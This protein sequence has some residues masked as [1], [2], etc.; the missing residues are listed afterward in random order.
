MDST[1]RT[2]IKAVIWNVIG[3]FSMAA[4]GFVAT[5]SLVA[6]G[7]MALVNTAIGMTMYVCYERVWARIGWG[8]HG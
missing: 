8:R 5:G 7:G 6:G 3:L 2:M 1:A 4:V